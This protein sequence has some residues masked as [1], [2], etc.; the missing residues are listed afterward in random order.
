M[1]QK[2]GTG[3]TMVVLL[4]MVIL[5][6]WSTNASANLIPAALAFVNAGAP[7]YTTSRLW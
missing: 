4:V 6:Q 5:S 1:I 2:N 3:I 7:K